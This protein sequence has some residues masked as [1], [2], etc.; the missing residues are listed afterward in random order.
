MSA[1]MHR[2]PIVFERAPRAPEVV[3]L[4]REITTLSA[5]I[6]ASMLSCAHWLNWKCGIGLNAAREKL[7]VAHAL[8]ALPGIRRE[9]E[10]GALSY[11]K[12]RAYRGL[13]RREE[14]ARAQAQHEERS[15][16]WH[17]DDDGSWVLQVRLP[18]ERGALVVAALEA[19]RERLESEQG[20]N[21]ERAS[22]SACRADALVA[23]AETALAAGE[24]PAGGGDR[25]Q[26][27]VHVDE[28]VLRDPRAE[29]RC[30]LEHGPGLA[31]GTAR[32]LACDAAVV[33]IVEDADG[34]PLEIGR[35]TRSIPPA[36]RR[37]LRSRDRGCR[38]P[39]CSHT[40]F[41]DA[42]HVT[43]WADGGETSLTNT[44]QRLD[45]GA[46]HFTGRNGQTLAASGD[47]TA[48]TSGCT[49][50]LVAA[51]RA[52]GLEIGAQTGR[53]RWDGSRL[54]LGLAAEGLLQRDG[55]L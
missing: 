13:L 17:H 1:S 47:V 35:K 26:V 3:A 7:R 12:V 28:A 31:A 46:L 48:V 36:L 27:V 54:D 53:S 52:A 41:L 24:A 10:R 2:R 40:R 49:G 25:H 23:T 34:T 16:R 6:Q 11:S 51:N 19:Q 45:H 8:E 38:F 21:G 4:E 5:H 22:F 39:G 32:R 44:V 20:E 43:H 18:A 37:A 15:L 33:R 55:G 42:H 29:G 30:E 9:F 50:A 14:A